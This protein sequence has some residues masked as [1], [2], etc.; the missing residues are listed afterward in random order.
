MEVVGACRKYD[1]RVGLY[2]S[3]VDWRFETNGKNAAAEAEKMRDLTHAQLRELMSNYGKIDLLWYD[4]AC[5]PLKENP[6]REDIAAFWQADKLNAMVRDLQPDIMI[7][8]R[9]GIDEDFGTI[10]ATNVASATPNSH[11]GNSCGFFTAK[12]ETLNFYLY[13]WPGC[14][15]RI[16]LLP[17]DISSVTVLKTGQALPFHRDQRGALI[18]SG[19]PQNPIDPLCTVLKLMGSSSIGV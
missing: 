13:G 9:S 12:G 15:T 19:L 2:Y 11:Q 10:E 18:I 14:E 16:P 3:L 4:G 5:C 1:L 8:N 17:K 7:N 6:S